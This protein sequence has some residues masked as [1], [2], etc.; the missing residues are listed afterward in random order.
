MKRQKRDRLSRAQTRGYQAGLEGKSREAC[1]YSSTDFREHW[2]GGW[3]EAKT[4][5]QGEHLL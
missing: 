4:Y 2:I 1:P 5:L 3:R